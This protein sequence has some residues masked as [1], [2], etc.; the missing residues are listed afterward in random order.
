MRATRLMIAAALLA[1]P[2]LAHASGASCA[3]LTKMVRMVG[4]MRDQG[5]SRTSMENRMKRDLKNDPDQR[6][7]ALSVIGLAFESPQHSPDTL[8]AM[9]LRTCMK[10]PLR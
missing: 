4:D 1:L 7:I 8:A 10:Q 2:L 5:V 9:M 3:E 6:A